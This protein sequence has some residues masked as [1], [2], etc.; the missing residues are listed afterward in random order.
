[1]SLIEVENTYFFS[2]AENLGAQN[3]TADGHKFQILLDNEIKVPPSAVDCTIEVR[4]ANI[5]FT[6][7]NI[8]AEYNNNILH[9]EYAGSPVVLTIP[10]GLYSV[11]ELNCTIQR[12]ISRELVP[13]SFTTR[14]ASNS[15]AFSTQTSRQRVIVKLIAGLSLLTVGAD[16]V[17][18]TLGLSSPSGYTATYDGEYF[19]AEGIAQLNRINSY[20]LQGD[21][22]NQGLSINN[23]YA[24]IMT[25]IQLSVSPGK[26]LT[27]RPYLP[28]KIDGNHLKYGSKKL[29]TFFL[30]DEQN[31]P[32]D[33]FGEN[34][35]FS[36]VIKYKVET[37]TTNLQGYTPTFRH[38]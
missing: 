25:E 38:Y 20:L 26:L 29:I 17:A 24:T 8:A 5:W 21:I 11:S 36:V 23:T 31:R 4:S 18:P 22:V 35:S 32:I 19:E 33:T 12:L 7:P 37:H 9:L 6:S 3:R 2:S 10:D 34:Y 15:I 13:P 27:Y 28:Y 30:T 1:M 14:F 16:N